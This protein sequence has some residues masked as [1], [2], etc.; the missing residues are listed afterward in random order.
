VVI[1]RVG[2]PLPAV[3]VAG[4]KL[5]CGGTDVSGVIAQLRFTVPLKPPDGVTVTLDVAV[6][7]SANVPGFSGVA[8]KENAGA[9]V[10]TVTVKLAWAVCETGPELAVIV[11]LVVPAALDAPVTTVSGVLTCVPPACT[12]TEAGEHETP[13]GNPEHVKVTDPLKSPWGVA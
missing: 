7:P 8:D 2:L 3:K 13:E 12:R 5:H 6:P 4:F 11:K 1:V 9:V 10:P